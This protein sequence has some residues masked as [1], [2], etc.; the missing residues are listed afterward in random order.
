MDYN[1]DDAR[2]T[3]AAGD[4]T[5]ELLTS[6]EKMTK[7]KGNGSKPML[8]LVWRIF[9]DDG[10]TFQLRDWVVVPDGVWKLKKLAQA[11]DKEEEFKA[12]KFQPSN[13]IGAGVIA[14][15]KVK[16]DDKYG[17]QNVIAN[18]KKQA[19][20]SGFSEALQRQLERAEQQTE[21]QF[22]TSAAVDDGCPF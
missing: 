12:A 8:E 19:A 18:Y 5:A 11:W 21:P 3:F 20:S 13:H 14:V 10:P 4:Y 7:D 9:T 2:K 15:I 1:P 6:T 17:E 22:A 16:H